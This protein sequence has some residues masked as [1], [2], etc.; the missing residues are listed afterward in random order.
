[1]REL[2]K[3]E[4]GR[5]SEVV[6]PSNYDILTNLESEEGSKGRLEEVV[7]TSK[8]LEEGNRK[9]FE[10]GNR[11]GLDDGT[12]VEEGGSRGLPCNREKVEGSAGG[13][14]ANVREEEE[15]STGQKCGKGRGCVDGSLDCTTQGLRV[16]RSNGEGSGR[17]EESEILRGVESKTERASKV[18]PSCYSARA[19]PRDRACSE[20]SL[21][22]GEVKSDRTRVR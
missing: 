12:L 11:K 6:E 17:A 15:G 10:V 1:M 4:L 14:I 16:G 3:L 20:Q 5:G 2:R 13:G 18:V 7:R 9:G 22:R 21:S 8:G 19:E